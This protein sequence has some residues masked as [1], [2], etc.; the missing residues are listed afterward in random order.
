MPPTIA[1]TVTSNGI[2]FDYREVSTGGKGPRGIEIMAAGSDKG[3][4]QFSP[5]DPNPHGNDKYNKNQRGFYD[6][7]ATSLA[8]GI[9][10]P[11]PERFTP[12]KDTNRRHPDYKGPKDWTKLSK[13]EQMN[14]LKKYN[15]KKKA[16]VDERNLKALHRDVNTQLRRKGGTTLDWGGVTYT[17]PKA[18]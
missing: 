8:R 2:R 1:G 9:Q 13:Q 16:E 14:E 17:L 4:I 7:L 18:K 6:A 12:L 11:E 3:Y 5:V 15:D 10:A